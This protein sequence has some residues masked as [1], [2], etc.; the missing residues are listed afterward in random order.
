MQFTKSSQSEG[1]T[2]RLRAGSP[3]LGV[4]KHPRLVM[5]TRKQNLDRRAVMNHVG[6]VFVASLIG[7]SVAALPSLASAQNMSNVTRP[8]LSVSKKRML[9]IR[10]TTLVSELVA[11][12]YTRPACISCTNVRRFNGS[13]GTDWPDRNRTIH[14]SSWRADA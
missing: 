3:D 11:P 2:R 12:T 14:Q 6:K 1:Y 10:G 13:V 4:H 7:L 5:R 8:S 9:N